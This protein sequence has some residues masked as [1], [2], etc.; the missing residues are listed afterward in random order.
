MRIDYVQGLNRVHV[1]QLDYTDDINRSL[2][3]EANRRTRMSAE[4]WNVLN[5][6]SFQPAAAGERL[7]QAGAPL[8]MLSAWLLLLTAGGIRAARRMQP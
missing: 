1:E 4:N 3:E 5:E 7:T 2:N 6:F 8:G